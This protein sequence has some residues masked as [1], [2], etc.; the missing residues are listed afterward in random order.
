MYLGR[1]D[2]YNWASGFVFW[3]S[4]LVFGC[5]DLYLGVWTC[6][7]VSDLV[8]EV[9]GLVFGCLTLYLKCLDLYL[10]VWTCILGTVY[11]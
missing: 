8:F 1:L 4:E 6:I 5:L 2:M 3:M 10:S 7:W 9:S 11:L